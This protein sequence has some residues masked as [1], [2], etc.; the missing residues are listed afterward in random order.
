MMAG[1][2]TPPDDL[3]PAIDALG[4]KGLMHLRA[5]SGVPTATSP[6]DPRNITAEML[7][8]SADHGRKYGES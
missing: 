4:P 8:L 6:V 1:V 7:A 5:M 3:Q 2:V